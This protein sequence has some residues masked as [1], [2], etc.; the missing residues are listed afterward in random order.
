[1]VSKMLGIQL[2][3][4]QAVRLETPGGGGYRPPAERDRAAVKRDVSR[5]LISAEKAKQDY[6]G[7]QEDQS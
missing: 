7:W 2:K 3:Q 5:G 6:P 4:G 1:M